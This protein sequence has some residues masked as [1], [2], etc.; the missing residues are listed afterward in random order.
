VAGKFLFVGDEKLYVRGVTYGTFRPDADGVDYPARA[1]V[2]ADFTA[3]RAAGVN[4]VRTY[5]APPAWL[6]DTALDNGLWVMVGIPWE[7]HV[8]FLNDPRRAGA[9]EARVRDGVRAVA[10]HPAT[11][12]VAIGNEIPTGIVRWHGARRLERS[13]ERLYRAAKAVDRDALVTYVN[14]PSTEY[15]R[16]PFLDVFAFNVYL[17]DRERYEAY[18]ARLHS[19]AGDRPLVMAEIG[20]DS[21][22]SGA[23]AQARSL[24]WQVRSAFAGGAAGAFAF[25][26]TDEWH[27][28]GQD[29]EEWDFGL[30]DRARR[31]KPALA[32]VSRAFA[33][34]P[35]PAA[36]VWP[37][38]SVVVC[39]YNGARTIRDCLDGLSQLDYPDYEVIVVNDGSTDATARI[40]S[41]YEVRLISTENRGLS[42]A[43]NTGAAAATGDLVAYT[44]D[45]ARPDPHWLQYLAATFSDGRFAAAGGPNIAPPGDGWIADCI[46]NAPGGPVHV[47]LDDCVAEHVPGC[48]LAFRREWLLAIGGFDAIYRAAGDDVDAC[49]RI[50]DARGVIGFSPA[51]MVWH[52][53]RNSIRRYW[54]QQCA[55]GKAEA[56]LEGKWPERYSALGHLSW[57]GRLYG[58]GLT[59]TLAQRGGRLYGG[60]WGRAAY[61]S[62]Y[63]PVGS[64]VWALPLMPEWHVV[65]VTLGAL[66]ALGVAWAPL[67]GFAP[68][69]ALALAAPM[70]QAAISAR[71]AMFTSEPRGWSQ[72]SR[73]GV[74]TFLLHLM[75]PVARLRGRIGYGLSLWRLRGGRTWRLPV[76]ARCARWTED[77]ATCEA[78]L[79]AIERSLK[80]QRAAVLRGGDF[81]LWDLELRPGVLAS[82]RLLL[83]VEEHGGGRQLLRFKVWPHV[84]RAGPLLIVAFA[85]LGVAAF[86]DGSPVVAI[87]L[88]AVA[89]VGLMRLLAEA[90]LAAGGLVGALA[91][92]P[93]TTS[94]DEQR[95]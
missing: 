67:L 2:G 48:N 64:S 39:S 13:I 72:R 65:V 68:F 61:Q 37:R 26:W 78:R 63:G 24:E 23:T 8:A 29:I 17:E 56:L 20:L 18:L 9:I 83:G 69:F 80:A 44:D 87:I 88:G 47:L 3:M 81:D 1:Q 22:R 54:T 79:E 33:A 76:V 34:V 51:A 32:A 71:R 57:A 30:V 82:A 21:R 42:A 10:P 53:R 95:R 31:P 12:M 74:V 50:R 60:T 35:F 58:K 19:L 45:D 27:R 36:G 84:S 6:L 15:L 94:L 91:T 66:V 73:L 75:Q 25:A 5:T 85:G 7:Q 92:V 77:W 62:L 59:A 38:V 16:L 14:Y 4:A 46:A 40:A 43:R 93:G 49:W 90:S 41:E 89:G 11:L 86:L 55:Y 28:G 70:L 52:H